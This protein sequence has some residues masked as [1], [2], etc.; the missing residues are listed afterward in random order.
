MTPTWLVCKLSPEERAALRRVLQST[1]GFTVLHSQSLLTSASGAGPAA[2][3]L[4]TLAIRNPI[5]AFHGHGLECLTCKAPVAKVLPPSG[6]GSTK[7]G[8]RICS[9][10]GPGSSASR[11]G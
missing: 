8:S 11:L 1:E 3:G 6:T 5:R 4:S 10:G 7:A 2:V 9:T